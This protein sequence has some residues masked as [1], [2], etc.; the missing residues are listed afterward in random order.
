MMPVMD[1]PQTLG[2]LREHEETA[3]IPVVFMT[4]RRRRAGSRISFR[5]GPPASFQSRSIP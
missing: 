5:S 3:E 1:G 2:H 4:A